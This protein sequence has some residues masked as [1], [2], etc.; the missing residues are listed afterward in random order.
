MPVE[1]RRKPDGSL[2]SKYWYGSYM[3]KGKRH[4]ASLE[5]PVGGKVVPASLRVPSDDEKFEESRRKAQAALDAIIAEAREKLQ[6]EEY[7]QKL[8]KIR[9]G[10]RI[11]S[12][13]L[14]ELS[15]AWDKAPRKRKGSKRY[16]DQAH[17]V[18]E[19]FIGFIQ[20]E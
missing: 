11:D 2:K 20:D 3:L 6:P 5:I 15:D 7:V 18:F 16:V 13:P 9:T 8:H 4:V 12:S 14:T 17:T 1:L 19:R 10:R